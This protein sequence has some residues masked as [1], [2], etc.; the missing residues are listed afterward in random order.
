MQNIIDYISEHTYD[1]GTWGIIKFI[2]D[3]VA[4]VVVII[5]IFLLV[6]K[7]ISVPRIL[8]ILLCYGILYLIGV[9][10]DLQ[11]FCSLLNLVGIFA[12]FFIVMIFSQDIKH[13]VEAFLSTDKVDNSYSSKEEKE[14]I[15]NVICST[16]EYLSERRIGA[17]ITFEREDNLDSIISKAIA[18]D[19]VVT[20]E[21]LTTI[22]TPGTACHDGGVIIRSNRVACAGAYYPATENFDVP[23][24][25]GTR[26]R[27]AIGISEKYDAITIIV[28][29]ETGNISL[30]IAGNI[31]L[32]IT[33]DR[34]EELLDSCL[35]IK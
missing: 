1:F 14:Q 34:L 26:H 19:S 2:I 33:I 13:T 24:F 21:I 6:K 22:F 4:V 30:T 35:N 20:Q 25:L 9:A 15:I 23:K 10:L 5:G 12:I 11:L 29:E 31:S 8:V 18:I 27:A 16:V 3:I 17:L 7:K 28:S 32:G